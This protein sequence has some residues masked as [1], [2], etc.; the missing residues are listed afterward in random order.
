[1]PKRTIVILCFSLISFAQA[2]AQNCS[3]QVKTEIIQ[4]T[5]GLDNGSV[6]FEVEGQ[7]GSK[8]YSIF[9]I[10]SIQKNVNAKPAYKFTNLA[11]GV[12]EFVVISHKKVRCTKEVQV[13]IEQQ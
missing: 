11:P 4:A 5:D 6:T 2:T 10:T 13:K 9:N 12:H 1:M 3:I 7:S 8:D